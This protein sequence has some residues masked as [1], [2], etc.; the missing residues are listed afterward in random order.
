MKLLENI[1]LD[2]NIIA[3]LLKDPDDLY[4]VWPIAKFPFDHQQWYEVLDPETGN[5][6]FLV[7]ENGHLIG[8]AALR[9]M[10]APHVYAVSFLYLLPHLRSRGLGAKMVACLEKYAKDKLQAPKLLLVVRTYNPAAL[11]CYAKCGFAEYDREGT[12]IK[13]S[14]NL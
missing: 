13:M 5:R 11:K 4:L 14:K 7:Y 8:H 6:P 3:Q 9:K 1:P 2:T 12:L 10:E